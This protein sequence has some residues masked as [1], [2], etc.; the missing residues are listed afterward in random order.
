MEWFIDL[1]ADVEAQCQPN[2][3]YVPLGV[4][5]PILVVKAFRST[6]TV[7]QPF[8]IMLHFLSRV[9]LLQT[10]GALTASTTSC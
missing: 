1:R 7:L 4:P 2:G 10:L 6:Y 9:E 5:N 3:Y 8:P